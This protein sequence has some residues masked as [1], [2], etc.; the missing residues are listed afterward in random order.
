MSKG[1]LYGITAY[2]LWGFFPIY[3]KLL[4]GVPA[5]QLL[6]HRIGWSF[7]LLLAVIWITGQWNDFRSTLGSRTFRI[8]LGAA[9]LIGVNWL[10]Y[11]WAVIAGFIVETSL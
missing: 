10:I 1:V 5:L 8:Y 2:A 7:I 4:H 6:G 3:W 9:F 11:V